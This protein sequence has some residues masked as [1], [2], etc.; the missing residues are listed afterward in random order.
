MRDTL[1]S[2]QHDTPEAIMPSRF[3]HLIPALMAIA[4]V[5]LL[6]TAAQAPFSSPSS[7]LRIEAMGPRRLQVEL[8]STPAGLFPDSART[9]EAQPR[10]VVGTP[11][12]VGIADSVR[13]LHVVVQGMGSVRLLFDSLPTTP[14]PTTP[15][16]G[17]DVTLVRQDDGRFRPVVRAHL[18]P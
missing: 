3:S 2:A 7:T 4:P 18:L 16:W 14:R 11:A 6:G 12:V 9:A 10:L 5:A 1:G 8:T 15:I 13:T 17:R